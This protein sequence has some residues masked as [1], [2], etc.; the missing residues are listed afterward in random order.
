MVLA[1]A[2]MTTINEAWAA[3]RTA[4]RMRPGREPVLSVLVR[5]LATKL[6]TWR[7]LRS[8]VLTAGGLGALDYAA[9]GFNH[10]Q[11]A[12]EHPV[13]RAG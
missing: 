1:P 6:P 10:L 3:G 4:R 9:Y 2:S 11:A 7:K 12:V 8:F 13:D 5:V